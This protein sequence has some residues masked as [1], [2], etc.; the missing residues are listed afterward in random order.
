MI[1][2]LLSNAF[3]NS[4]AGNRR[5]GKYADE[6]RG[7]VRAALPGLPA[8]TVG[9]RLTAV[10]AAYDAFMAAE[11]TNAVASAVRQGKTVTNDSAIRRFQRFITQQA[12][13]IGGQLDD[14]DQGITGTKTASYQEFFPKGV[15]A[16]T[17]ANK[18][19]IETE[20]DTFLQAA[21]AHPTL[22]SPGLAAKVQALLADIVTSRTQQLGTE[23][24]GGDQ[25]AD[26]G[27]D[28]ARR[29]LAVAEFRLMLALLDHHAE[30]PEE[31]AQY[32]NEGI[33]KEGRR[34]KGG[35]GGTTPTV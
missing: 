11:K 10:D 5:F 7:R 30:A 16:L 1:E 3:A 33:M 4:R 26:T 23:G 31:V 15:T 25:Q 6:Y 29:T 19:N 13:L 22:G 8:A 18:A 24:K 34:R 17:E 2:N 28:A 12:K 27:R 21:T 20:A 35:A 9:V 14:P 32:V